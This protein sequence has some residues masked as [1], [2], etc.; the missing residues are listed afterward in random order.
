MAR[1][2]FNKDRDSMVKEY[3]R[4]ANK[5]NNLTTQNM[6]M[7]T[8]QQQQQQA[9]NTAMLPFITDQYKTA[10]AKAQAEQALQDPATQI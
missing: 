7:Y 6:T 2:K 10:Q 5:A 1:D 3:T 8:T 4:Y 9:Q